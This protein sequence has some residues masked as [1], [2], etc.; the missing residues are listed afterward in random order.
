V[1]YFC[2]EI[3][4]FYS[5]TCHQGAWDSQSSGTWDIC[6]YLARFVASKQFRPKP[7]WLQNLGYFY[8]KSRM[9]TT[10]SDV[11][12]TCGLTCSRTSLTMQLTSGG[13]VCTPVF[14]PEEDNLSMHCD[15]RTILINAANYCY[16]LIVKI[17][18]LTR[19][20]F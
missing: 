17:Y 2:L 4:Y 3:A 11:W 12:L 10:W 13:S 8:I 18:R 16:D 15:S 19:Y 5:T 14:E 1:K 7:S 6:I 9:R 20:L